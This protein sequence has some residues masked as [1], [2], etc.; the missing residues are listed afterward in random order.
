MVVN[1][2]VVLELI[3]TPAFQRLKLIDQAGYF[4]PYCPGYKC[5]RYDHSLGVFILLKKFK[6]GLKEQIAGLIHDLSHAAFSHCIDYVLDEGSP[7]LHDHQDNIFSLFVLKTKLPEILKKYGFDTNYILDEKNFPLKE[8]QLP[9]LCADR[10]DYSLRTGFIAKVI[11]KKFIK[12]ILDNLLVKDSK[13]VF[14]NYFWAKKY[15]LFFK[16]MNDDYFAGSVSAQMFLTVG[17]FLKHSLKKNYINKNDLYTTDNQVLIKIKKYLEKDTKLNIL[18]Q[19]M[20]NKI[21]AKNNPRNYDSHVFV[22]SRAVDPLFKK[23][24]TIMRF[25]DQYPEWKKIVKKE[26]KPKEYFLKFEK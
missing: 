2:P 6:A 14:K 26:L 17:D 20:N 1:E 9:D 25:S 5:S 8:K 16:K 22:K 24:N 13:W 23:G 10:I 15:G 19:R 12:N 18:W 7:Q 3:K 4:H 11:N 21:K